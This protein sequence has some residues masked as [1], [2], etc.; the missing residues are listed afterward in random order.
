VASAS[1]Y[2]TQAS[3][4]QASSKTAQQSFVLPELLQCLV[5][6]WS[7]KRGELLRSVAENESWQAAV[8]EDV[9]EFLRSVFQ[10]DVPL[11]IVDLPPRGAASYGQLREM[12]TQACSLNRSLLVVC[13]AGNDRDEEMWARQLGAWAYLPEATDISGLRMVFAEA[14]KALAMKSTTYVEASGYR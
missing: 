10:L 2:T 5:V 3:L 6:S 13:G 4:G 12:A 7:D 14:R 9:Q 8:C 11:T 1:T